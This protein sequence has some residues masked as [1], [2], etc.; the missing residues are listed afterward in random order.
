M[1][2]DH[3][4]DAVMRYADQCHMQAGFVAPQL[5]ADEGMQISRICTNRACSWRGSTVFDLSSHRSIVSLHVYVQ[6]SI[7]ASL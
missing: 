1:I 5:V 4:L 2:K 6:F 3:F 7:A